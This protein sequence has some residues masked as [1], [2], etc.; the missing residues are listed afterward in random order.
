MSHKF[1]KLIEFIGKLESAFEQAEWEEIAKLDSTIKVIVGDCTS[2]ALEEIDRLYLKDLL[3][4][5]QTLYDRITT[6]SIGHRAELGTELKKLNKDR[7]AISQ[8]I[9]SSGY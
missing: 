8:Y 5:L 1:A 7:N 4:K 3:M 6:E 2:M 9:Q